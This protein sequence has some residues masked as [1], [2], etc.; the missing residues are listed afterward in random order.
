M[1]LSGTISIPSVTI[2]GGA[3]YT[4]NG[5]L[6]VT[7]AFIGGGTLTNGATGNL[8][9]AFAWA[10]QCPCSKFTHCR[11]HGKLLFCR[12]SEYCKLH[13]SK[14]YTFQFRSKNFSGSTQ[15]WRMF[16]YKRQ[17]AGQHG[18]IQFQYSHIY[19]GRSRATKRHVFWRSGSKLFKYYIFCCSG[20]SFNRYCL[21]TC[22][23]NWTGAVSTDRNT[24]GNWSG[25]AVPTAAT[26]VFIPSAPLINLILAQQADYATVLPFLAVP[27]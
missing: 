15:H 18:Y 24:A 20:W 3:T 23:G 1:S 21:P 9:I 25:N 7:T 16:D 14:P 10:G 19:N 4:N 12:R 11:Q 6:T 17:C 26:D 22:L 27:L 8:N 5:V 13:L 2:G